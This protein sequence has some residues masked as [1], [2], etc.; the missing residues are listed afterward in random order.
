MLS[1]EPNLTLTLTLTLSEPKS[2]SLRGCQAFPTR[3]IVTRANV[4]SSQ[5][6]YNHSI[7]KC[8]YKLN[9]SKERERELSYH[10]R[11]IPIDQDILIGEGQVV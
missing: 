3:D 7:M 11:Y 9:L 5:F 4:G 1:L 10:G 8:E 2:K 6:L